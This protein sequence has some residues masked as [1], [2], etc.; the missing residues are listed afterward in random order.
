MRD[1]GRLIPLTRLASAVLAATLVTTLMATTFSAAPADVGILVNA[2]DATG[3]LGTRIATQ[4]AWPGGLGRAAGTRDRFNAL[5]V[6]LARINATTIVCCTADAAPMIPAGLVKGDWNFSSLDSVVNDIH[7]AGAQTFLTIAYAPEWMWI[8]PQGAIRDGTFGEFADYMARVVSYY[9]RGSLIAEDGR[10]VTN[11]AGTT[12]RITYWGLWNEPNLRSDGCPPGGFPYLGVPEY[13]AMWNATAASMLAVDPTIKL[14]GPTTAHGVTGTVPDY[15]PALL[16]SA[17]HQ[18]DV[19][20]F[21]DY[22]GWLN[23]QTDAFFFNG[24]MGCCG[25]DAIT[26]DL[27]QVREWAPGIPVWITELNVNA[28]WNEDD[29][30]RRPWSAYGAAWGASAF[31]R[32]ARA[33][34]DVVFQYQFTH[35]ALR[36]FSLVDVTTGAP[37][38]PYWRDY[39]LARYFPPG[40]TIFAASTSIGDIEVLAAR[41][42]D[43]GNVRVLVVNRQVDDPSAVG[44]LGLPATVTITVAGLPDVDAV[45]VRMLDASTPLDTGP[46]A[47]SLPARSTAT[48]NFSGY[49]AALLEFSI[50]STAAPA[51]TSRP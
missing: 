22:G 35:P 3:T 11:P 47:V 28:A 17:T 20:S 43:S 42:P 1:G 8:C 51:R 36:Q 41:P 13:I 38:L 31:Q 5:G 15:L 7:A 49:G 30:T 10:T 21:N 27:A 33:G 34:A 2:T 26:R 37:L 39:Y 18:P 29:P 25:L 24:D 16:G 14:V 44:G 48:I 4:F 40:S 12:N 9:N 45:T 6:G 32:L 50:G 46:L 19:V 23:T